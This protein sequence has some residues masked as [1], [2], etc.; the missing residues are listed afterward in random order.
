MVAG[1]SPTVGTT[2][3]VGASGASDTSDT[4]HISGSTD[5]MHALA[6]AKER[7][8]ARRLSREQ[9]MPPALA[10]ESVLR[11]VAGTESLDALL[12]R[13][14]VALQKDADRRA[15][16]RKASLEKF[17]GKAAARAADPAA[18][19]AWFDGSATPNPGRIGLGCVLRAPDGRM[20]EISRPAG[21]GDSNR[22]EYLALIAVLAL[23]GKMDVPHL[24]IHGDSR[25]VIDDVTAREPVRVPDLHSLREQVLHLLAAI[26]SVH[27][28]W[29]PRARNAGADALARQAILN[30]AIPED[31]PVA[32]A[33]S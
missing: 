12:A 4:M 5:R 9:S 19:H 32:S 11:Q 13:R 14:E 1:S 2:A 21:N 3:S 20:L 10:L 18:W 22:A 29:I 24:V 26:P 17:R 28:I 8:M 33:E 31:R 16:R 15:G 30:L 27:F 23:A 7:A 6:H 25:I